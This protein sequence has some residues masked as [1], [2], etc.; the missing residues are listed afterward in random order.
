MIIMK[1]IEK[2]INEL[3]QYIEDLDI[4]CR[5]DNTKRHELERKL[6][7]TIEILEKLI[8]ILRGDDK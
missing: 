5:A 6:D 1:D 7:I 8:R 3:Y 4:R 2:R